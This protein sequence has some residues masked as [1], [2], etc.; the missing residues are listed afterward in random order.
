MKEAV[1][2]SADGRDRIEQFSCQL[3]DNSLGIGNRLN[4]GSCAGVPDGTIRLTPVEYL[5][6]V[7]HGIEGIA[8]LLPDEDLEA[9]AAFVYG[10][11]NE[12]P[13]AA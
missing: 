9:L 11:S 8:N 12:R 3:P 10:L 5:R 4:M 13:R 2:T 1:F 6:K 7:R